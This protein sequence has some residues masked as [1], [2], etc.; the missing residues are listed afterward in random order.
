MIYYEI[1]GHCRRLADVPKDATI[2]TVNGREC[3]GLCE[4]CG[5]PVLD[6][7]ESRCDNDG[8]W[9]HVKCP[10]LPEGFSAPLP[11]TP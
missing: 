8:V 5:R 2:I 3:F 10:A 1:I 4:V 7:Q 9:W 11:R 6:G